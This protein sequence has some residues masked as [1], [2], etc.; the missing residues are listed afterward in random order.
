MGIFFLCIL[1][2]EFSCSW[3]TMIVCG[4]GCVA[5]KRTETIAENNAWERRVHSVQSVFNHIL[6]AHTFTWIRRNQYFRSIRRRRTPVTTEQTKTSKQIDLS[7]NRHGKK[8][9]YCYLLWALAHR[10]RMQKTVVVLWIF[11][12]HSFARALIYVISASAES[13][14]IVFAIA[15]VCVY[16]ELQ[17]TQINIPKTR[18]CYFF[19]FFRREV[20]R[21]LDQTSGIIN[22]YCKVIADRQIDARTVLNYNYIL[23]VFMRVECANWIGFS[24]DRYTSI[25]SH[26]SRMI[27]FLGSAEVDKAG[28]G[29]WLTLLILV[30]I[31]MDE[32]LIAA[33]AFSWNFFLRN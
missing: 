5:T 17:F 19:L 25:R 28:I 12:F 8:K 32:L 3:M 33:T 23:L 20:H 21:P 6:A 10:M 22:I 29:Q 9:Q 31:I 24:R 14:I 26:S 2:G 16:I 1:T 27:L 30:S 18:M 11:I 13:P 15:M 7:A 4:C